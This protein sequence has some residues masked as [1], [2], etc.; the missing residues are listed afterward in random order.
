MV[1][2]FP[3]CP[4]EN[5]VFKA[6]ILRFGSRVTN[7]A[8][9][10]ACALYGDPTSHLSNVRTVVEALLVVRGF[11]PKLMSYVKVLDGKTM[12]IIAV[13]QWVYE[14]DVDRGFLG[15]ALAWGLVFPY[16]P[17][18][19]TEYL[20]EQ[21]V[22]LKRR[23]ILELLE[24][25]ISDFPELSHE[26]QIEPEYFMYA[27]VVRRARLFPPMINTLWN[28]IRP[29]S[30]NTQRVLAGYLDA[31]KELEE[32]GIIGFSGDYVRISEKFISNAKSPR[33]RL[34]NI[35]KA[36]PRTLFTSLLNVMPR[37][38][39]NLPENNE[40]LKQFLRFQ[41]ATRKSLGHVAQ[42][43]VPENYLHIPTASGLVS[44]ANRMDIQAFARKVLHTSKDAEIKVKAIGGVLN[45]VYLVEVT[46]GS[47]ETRVVVKE[48]K[49]WSSFKWFPLSLWGVGTK[50]FTV[51]G[52]SRLERECATNELLRSKG[53]SVPKLLHVSPSQRLVFM[54]Y[55]EGE[56]ATAL[57]RRI[58][59]SEIASEKRK[60]LKIVS[61]I[62]EKLAGVH[63]LDIAL[64]DA[65]P[66][67][68]LIGKNGELYLMDFEQ[69]SR[70][71]DMS[72]DVAEFLYYAGHDLPILT[73]TRQVELI[74]RAFI[75][76]YLTAG[77][78]V[79]TVRKAGTAKYTKVF[80]VFTLPHFMLT[81]SNVLRR[82]KNEER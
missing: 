38:L 73:E 63:A 40:S 43:M 20:Y 2:V 51:L 21:E 18:I 70:S 76:G 61:R 10:V 80:S 56:P 39:E 71:G 50:R 66:E 49:D 55:V 45:E 25:L 1:A 32:R 77:G 19:N 78:D 24:N 29:S 28:T 7:P 37:L 14:R 6:E 62:G 26:L 58:A 60:E 79:E 3:D 74:C 57:L 11:Q 23:L 4:N 8:N 47:R 81:I 48:F 41:A 75:S 35:S 31:L 67:N 5:D 27:T 17:L 64:G 12:V 52:R 34:F 54:E 22:K 68:V 42:V 65:K 33:T 16:L 72:W 44:M 15:E 36:V 82:T 53:F 69:A 13:D 59:R 9:V 46:G 30:R